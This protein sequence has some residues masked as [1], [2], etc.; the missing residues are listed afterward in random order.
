MGVEK[1][2]KREVQELMR[3]SGSS[4]RA[5]MGPIP[6]LINLGAGDPDFNQPEFVNKAVYES[7]RAGQTH[8]SFTGEPDFNE[9]ISEYYKKY[10][11]T[12]DP[13]TQ[14][15]ITSGGSQAILQAFGAI[16]A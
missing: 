4:T 3:M 2:A 5:S 15:L 6:G 14:V 9:A 8:Y 7:M 10:G 16:I 13:K 11:V 1:F 12:V